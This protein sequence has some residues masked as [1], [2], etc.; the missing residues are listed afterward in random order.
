MTFNIIFCSLSC[1]SGDI[2]YT[3]P[4]HTKDSNYKVLSI[5]IEL[6]CINMFCPLQL[7]E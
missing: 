1:V 7:K 3:R 5:I 4:V 2:C 6:H